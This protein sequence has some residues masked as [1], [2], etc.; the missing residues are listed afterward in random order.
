V[1]REEAGLGAVAEQCEQ[2]GEPDRGG[3]EVRAGQDERAD[4]Q[5]VVLAEDLV[6]SRKIALTASARR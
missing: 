1:H 3:R 6:A 4:G 5:V 2:E